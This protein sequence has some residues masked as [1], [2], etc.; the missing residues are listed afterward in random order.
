MRLAHQTPPRVEKYRQAYSLEGDVLDCCAVL[1]KHPKHGITGLQWV[2][3]TGY[4]GGE[5]LMSAG[6]DG[7]FTIVP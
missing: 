7:D 1:E 4:F 5:G 2:Q 6:S 3:G